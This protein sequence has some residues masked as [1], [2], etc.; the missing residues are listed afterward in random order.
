MDLRIAKD[1]WKK[2]AQSEARLHLLV[3]LGYLQVGFPDIEQFCLD[4]ESKYRE[5]AVGELRDKGSKSPE[6]QIVKLC[7]SLR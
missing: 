2:L 4:L 5:R 1:I 6:W 7:M 3:E